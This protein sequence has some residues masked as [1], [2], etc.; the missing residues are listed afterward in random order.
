MY[1]KVS[2]IVPVYNSMPYLRLCMDSILQQ[3]YQN[4]EVIVIDDGSSDGSAV[5]CDEYQK[6]DSRVRVVHN[7]NH[8]VSYSRNRGI[9]MS[10][11]KYIVFIDS[12]DT[13]EE[14]YI[15]ALVSAEADNNVDLVFCNVNYI[16]LRDMK[17]V[18]LDRERVDGDF[19][20]DYYKLRPILSSPWLKLYKNDIIKNNEIYFS[21]DISYGEDQLFNFRYFYFVKSYTFINQCLYNYYRRSDNSLSQIQNM[22]NFYDSIYIISMEENLLEKKNVKNKESVIMLMHTSLMWWYIEDGDN[23]YQGFRKRMNEIKKVFNFAGRNLPLKKRL[24]LKALQYDANILL[25][26]YFWF[27][28]KNIFYKHL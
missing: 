24:V 17:L 8:G 13:I 27:K 10:T 3:T 15:E 7:A 22:K 14:T 26:I 21:E 12:D 20:D 19:F 5:V 16:P 18:C 25:Y 6:K 11:G 1:D 28:N 4:I 9:D 23:T 2:V